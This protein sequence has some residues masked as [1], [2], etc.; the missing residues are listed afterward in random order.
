LRQES[1]DELALGV[2][3]FERGN[4]GRQN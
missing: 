3:L 2:S 4:D 1:L